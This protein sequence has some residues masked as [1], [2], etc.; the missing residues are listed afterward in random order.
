MKGCNS[1]EALYG[2]LQPRNI[3]KTPYMGVS[4]RVI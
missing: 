1:K 2:R 4:N 3:V